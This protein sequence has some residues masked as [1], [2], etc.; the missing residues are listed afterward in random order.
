MND[1]KTQ[2]FWTSLP[3]ILTGLASLITAIV[4]LFGFFGHR[5]KEA[6]TSAPSGVVKI[7]NLDHCKEFVGK[8][9]WFIGGELRA[10]KDG[11]VDW[12]KN[13][14]DPQP[15]IAGRWTCIDAKPKQVNISWPNGISETLAFSPD[16]NSL[17]GKNT[18]GVQVSGT[19][20]K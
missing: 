14:S 4:A 5:E 20:N 1:G 3:G 17:S 15:V 12:R 19:K 2:S 6:Q 18:I 10:Q 7:Q 16:K 8:W 9:D 13:E 11:S